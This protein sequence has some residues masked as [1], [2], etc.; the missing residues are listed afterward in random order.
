MH[1]YM[2]TKV[3]SERG[4]VRRY[5]Q[6]WATLGK[7][8]LI[9][10]GKSSAKNG[11]LMDVLGALHEHGTAVVVFDETEE[12]PSI[13]M[14]MRVRELGLREN[15]DFVIGIGGG[16]PM[17]AAKAI[18]LMLYHKEKGAEFLYQNGDDE[19]LPVVE[20][21]TTC[22]TGS[23]VTPYAI[24]TIHAKRTKSSLPHRIYPA[25]AL[26]DGKYLLEAGRGILV[27]T[28]VDALG[29]FIESYINANATDYSHM[30]C[31]YGMK[32]WSSTK[33]VLI[34]AER[35]VEDCDRLL[36]AS[37]IAGMAITHTGTALPHGLSYYLTYENHV[38]H[39]RAVGY[40]LP[41]YVA[42]ADAAMRRK[43]LEL[44]GFPDQAYF[45]A[46]IHRLLGP[47]QAEPEL[48]TRAVEGI[49]ANEA[50]LKNVPFSVTEDILN[51]ICAE[52]NLQRKFT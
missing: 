40:F 5:S 52:A 33:S 47:M 23:E 49:L 50:K 13:E 14:V 20:V 10:T 43:V 6:E 15:V 11:A 46:F 30:L 35:T 9:V 34:G 41:G 51:S 45:T 44:I 24:L 3:Y 22:G 36:L 4:C 8:A 21:P 17:D 18:A 27:N 2:P 16:S 19:A 1:F 39:G 37:T 26:A 32:V 25:Y 12:N 7:K 31:E 42:A 29:H 48:I 38:P 28:A